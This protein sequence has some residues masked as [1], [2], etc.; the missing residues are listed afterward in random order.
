M[1]RGVGVNTYPQGVNRSAYT[2]AGGGAPV[3]GVI[4]CN[5][6]VQK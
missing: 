3:V 2:G 6:N 1:S 5:S 4:W